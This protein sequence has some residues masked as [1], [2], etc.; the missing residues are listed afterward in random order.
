MIDSNTKSKILEFGYQKMDKM[1]NGDDIP[2]SLEYYH[3]Y[4]RYIL[5]I[6]RP[7][8]NF[9]FIDYK[10]DSVGPCHTLFHLNPH[11]EIIRQSEFYFSKS[12]DEMK[13]EY[14]DYKL[15]LII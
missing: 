13:R 7:S 2:K 12:L 5:I 4:L 15:G 3:L 9:Y 6:D 11:F 1:F 10:G 14:R 8:N